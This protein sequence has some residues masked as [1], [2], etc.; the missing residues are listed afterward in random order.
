MCGIMGIFN[1]DGRPVSPVT[2][3]K[4]T[5]AI[6]HR[7]P[8]GEG[9]YIDSF[10]GLGHRRLA[11]IDLSS[12]GHQPMTSPCENYSIAFNGEVY[13]FKEL[14]SVLEAQGHHFISRT[15]TEVVLHAYMEWGP[16]CVERFNSMFAFVL[17]DKTRQSLFLARD[18]YGIKPLY[19]SFQ[20]SKFWNILLSR[21]FS[22]IRPCSRELSFFPPQAGH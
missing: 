20:G 21:I 5:D 22:Q 13:N 17:W 19:Y 1:L 18:R 8:D 16:S 15:D 6:A 2:L 7:G 3:R 14:R 10:L 11:V 9:F 12:A 4:M